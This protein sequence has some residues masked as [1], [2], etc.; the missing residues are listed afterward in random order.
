MTINRDDLTNA[1]GPQHC[2]KQASVVKRLKSACLYAALFICA[3]NQPAAF[4]LGIIETWE[5]SG[6]VSEKLLR[7]V[8]V[9]L[10]MA[11]MWPFA[12]TLWSVQA[13]LGQDTP[14]DL[15]FG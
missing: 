15:F 2:K 10:L 7:N 11:A 4:V 9:D 14:L 1:E 5:G 13:W 3:I 12:W 8:T 6:Y